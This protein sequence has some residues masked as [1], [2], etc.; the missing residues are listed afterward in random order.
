MLYTR[1]MEV[2]L[3][4]HTPVDVAPGTC[5][6]QTDVPLK[7]TFEAEAAATKAALE[8]YGPFD[9]V[10]TSPLSRCTRLAGFCGYP[11]AVCDGRLMEI[12]FGEWEMKRFDDI[13]DERLQEYY[14]DFLHTPPTGGESF[15]EM[16][17][18]VKD[19]LEEMRCKGWR[20]IS[21]FSHGGV[22]L[23]ALLYVGRADFERP[24]DSLTPHG[25]IISIEL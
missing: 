25:G 1:P 21:V 17:A 2:V 23:C 12:N 16:Y 19:F 18:R 22:L 15:M 13:T 24:F 10:F 6:G 11:D 5:Y 14:N 4:R 7:A 3:I 9:R 20:R 8:A